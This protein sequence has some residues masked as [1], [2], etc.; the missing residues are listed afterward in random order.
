MCVCSSDIALVPIE[1]LA[2]YFSVWRRTTAGSVRSTGHRSRCDCSGSPSLV[3]H[4]RN[5]PCLAACAPD[6]RVGPAAGMLC[7]HVFA[8]IAILYNLC[9]TSTSCS[10]ASVECR[11]RSCVLPWNPDPRTREKGSINTNTR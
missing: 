3:A 2:E 4:H 6:Q 1:S 8:Y 5:L 10:L 9:L 11:C 7:N